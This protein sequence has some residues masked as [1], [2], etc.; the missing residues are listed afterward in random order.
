MAPLKL[1]SLLVLTDTAPGHFRPPWSLP[2]RCFQGYPSHL[3]CE[4]SGLLLFINGSSK[5]G[6]LLSTHL[7]LTMRLQ[8]GCHCSSHHSPI[9]VGSPN[10]LHKEELTLATLYSIKKANNFTK[11][12]HLPS[13]P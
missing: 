10:V 11:A 1:F 7:P 5:K 13:L 2:Y 9:K 8:T 12:P 6:V 3:S 4:A